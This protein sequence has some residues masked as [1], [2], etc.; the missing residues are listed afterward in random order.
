[1]ISMNIK[2]LFRGIA[3]I[4]DD[5]IN[6]ENSQI[7]SIKKLIQA[8]NI[9]VATYSEIPSIDIIPQLSSAAF[10]I[11]DWEFVSKEMQDIDGERVV[12]GDSFTSDSKDQV[13][14]LLKEMLNNIFVPIFIFTANN[15]EIVINSLR[16][17]ELWDDDERKNKVFI[18]QKDIILTEDTLF[19]AIDEWMKK[20]PSAYVLK[21]WDNTVSKAKNKLFLDMYQCS[22]NWVGIIWKML[23]EDSIEHHRE[24]GEFLTQ[25][26]RNRV[27]EYT[28][29]EEYL[30][31]DGEI[32]N[33]ELL[34]VLE[35]ERY[36]GYVKQPKQLYTGDLFSASKGKYYLNIQ[37]QCDL[38]RVNCDETEEEDITLLCL[39]GRKLPVK[40]I[41]TEDIYLSEEGK[42][43]FSDGKEYTLE[44]LEKIK[45]SAES[46]QEVN[47]KFRKQR[48]GVFY[49]R[50][51]ILEKKPEVIISCV[52]NKEVLRFELKIV[53]MKLEEL[54]DKRI[55]RILPPYI[56]RIQQK[57]SQYLLREGVLPTPKEMFEN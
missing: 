2:E 13:I 55:G 46:L 24:F 49:N 23:K 25:N 14:L 32:D 47:A 41:I 31:V 29:E 27:D 33:E 19:S 22:P 44:E 6:K 5:E 12:M 30:T 7:A 42:L 4:I 15:P 57:C 16:E 11:L 36:V 53:P 45:D 50:G 51:E 20:T 28:F 26:L 34:S 10:V 3:V 54:K 18:R 38:A 8:Q 52:A 21:E 17:N 56:T 37:A 35:G 43:V 9:P 48:N 40:Q 39:V 1:M